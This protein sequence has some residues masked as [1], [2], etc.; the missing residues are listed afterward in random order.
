MASLLGPQWLCECNASGGAVNVGGAGEEAAKHFL[1]HGTV[2]V[3]PYAVSVYKERND[4]LYTIS[5]Q[6]QAMKLAYP[7][8]EVKI[9]PMTYTFSST[10]VP[11]FTT[12]STLKNLMANFNWDTGR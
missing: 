2:G 1:S 3:F 4:W 9:E 6:E 5:D 7:I 8:R 11:A 12:S 10:P